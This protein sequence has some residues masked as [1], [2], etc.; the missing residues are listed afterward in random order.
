MV[1]YDLKVYS[2]QLHHIILFFS[3]C[4]HGI[5]MYSSLATNASFLGNNFEWYD[6]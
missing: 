6:S 4:M 1:R 5:Q 2:I 3:A